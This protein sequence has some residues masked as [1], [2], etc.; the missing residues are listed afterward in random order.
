M[1]TKS[2]V[3]FHQVTEAATQI[4]LEF[5]ARNFGEDVHPLE[6]YFRWVGSTTNHQ[7][8]ALKIL[9]VWKLRMEPWKEEETPSFEHR[10]IFR[11]AKY[12]GCR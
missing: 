2:Q 12:W 11:F 6:D 3:D 1:T 8:R 10:V 7:D 5:S 9:H 4:F